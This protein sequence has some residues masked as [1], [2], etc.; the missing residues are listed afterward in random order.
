MAGVHCS[1]QT[2]PGARSGP[3]CQL[4]HDVESGV[5]GRVALDVQMR[6]LLAPGAWQGMVRAVV[7]QKRVGFGSQLVASGRHPTLCLGLTKG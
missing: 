4:I 7:A 3:G 1:I 2:A 5:P 6:L